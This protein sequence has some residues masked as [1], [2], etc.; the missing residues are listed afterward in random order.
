MSGVFGYLYAKHETKTILDRDKLEC[1]EDGVALQN[2]TKFID[3]EC[4]WSM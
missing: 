2:S 1:F 4:H 3:G